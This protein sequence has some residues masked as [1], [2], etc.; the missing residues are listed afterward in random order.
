VYLIYSFA[1]AV[2]LAFY[3][4]IYAFR[5][6]VLKKDRVHFRE[7][8]ALGFEKRPEGRDAIWIHAVSV[9]EVLSLQHLV[10]ELKRRHPEWDIVFSTL[11]HTGIK[12]AREKLVEADRI[13]FV[14]LDFRRVIR[15]V[16]RA[17]RPG[18]LVLAESE[19]WPNLVGEAADRGLKVLLINGRISDH[20]FKVYEDIRPVARRILGNVDR[21]LVQTDED[22][23]RLERLGIE[24]AR[25]EVA[26][27]LKSE[28]RLPAFS[29][30]E[31]RDFKRSLG[32]EGGESVVVAGSTRKGE[33]E[34][35]LKAFAEARKERTGL[36][37]IV[38]PRHV[39]RAGEIER[40]A[41]ATGFKVVRRTQA[42]PDDRWDLLVL[43]TIG[44]LARVYALSDAAFVGGS[45]VDW[46][47]HNILEPA[48]Y[49]KPVFFGPH[50]QNFARLADSFIRAGGARIVRT[51]PELVEMFLL[52]D[53]EALGR[54]GAQART[55]LA[56]LG[57]ATERTI[58]AIEWAMA[59]PEP[60]RNGGNS[61]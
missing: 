51:D 29:E 57:G 44:E 43:D 10:G 24:P 31:L 3:L 48:Y 25:L 8:L 56:S 22:R 2:A 17:V 4:P 41:Q 35:L 9:G 33:E 38:A 12:V 54:M 58:R 45:L 6:R 16:F 37:F 23:E 11:T 52:R 47:G 36:R 7:R 27:N 49:G 20:T 1:L 42:R 28:I 53:K 34:R 55:H 40:A 32:L 61:E 18:A 21:F 5:M 60:D 59:R 14:P 26:G 15:R 50:M 39:E 30:G 19:F 46:G 13:F